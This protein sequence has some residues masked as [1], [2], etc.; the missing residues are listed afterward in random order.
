MLPILAALLPV[1]FSVVTVFDV[2]GVGGLLFA[3]V[4][5]I[6]VDDSTNIVAALWSSDPG[7]PDA[8]QT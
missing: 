5:G 1:L 7:I 6:T 3:R 2:D 8:T 4:I